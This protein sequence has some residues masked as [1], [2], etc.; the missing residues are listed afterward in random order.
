MLCG[1]ILYYVPESRPHARRLCY[2]LI[3]MTANGLKSAL[4]AQES[5]CAYEKIRSKYHRARYGQSLATQKCVSQ[6]I[7]DDDE[8]DERPQRSMRKKIFTELDDETG[9]KERKKCN[10]THKDHRVSRHRL[11]NNVIRDVSGEPCM[12]IAKPVYFYSDKLD[13]IQKYLKTNVSSAKR[14][15]GSPVENYTLL[16]SGSPQQ[17]AALDEKYGEDDTVIVRDPYARL[18]YKEC[19]TSTNE[20]SSKEDASSSDQ[21]GPTRDRNDHEM[22]T[23]AKDAEYSTMPEVLSSRYSVDKS[24]REA[25][26]FQCGSGCCG[27]NGCSMS[28]ADLSSGAAVTSNSP[29][30]AKNLLKSSRSMVTP[31]MQKKIEQSNESLYADYNNYNYVGDRTTPINLHNSRKVDF[32]E[33]IENDEAR[34][35]GW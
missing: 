14:A 30:D 27:S 17:M 18:E 20:L 8:N 24:S 35:R 5:E 28:T 16:I 3:D 22:E 31:K 33:V 32:R 6:E 1:V 9:V 15:N 21:E 19:G 13:D 26:Q 29:V 34:I 7:Q 25:S 4:S 11:R 12:E 2:A 10:K 23:Y